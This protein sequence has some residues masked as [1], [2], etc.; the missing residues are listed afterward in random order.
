MPGTQD[1]FGIPSGPD[2]IPPSSGISSVSEAMTTI[3]IPGPRRRLRVGGH[4]GVLG[5]RLTGREA[6]APWVLPGGLSG[7]GT[8]NRVNLLTP[9]S[10]RQLPRGVELT[11]A[12]GRTVVV[13]VDPIDTDTSGWFTFYG[14]PETVAADAPHDVFTAKGPRVIRR[15]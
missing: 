4:L 15:R 2:F 11:S 5:L 10:L 3:D 13:G 7:D 1:G 6:Y 8:V 14:I 9:R 12:E